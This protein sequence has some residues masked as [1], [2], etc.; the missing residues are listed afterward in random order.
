VGERVAPLATTD[1]D[2]PPCGKSALELVREFMARVDPP[3]RSSAGLN[4]PRFPE[5]V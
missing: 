4:A 2:L 3:G 5:S 1:V